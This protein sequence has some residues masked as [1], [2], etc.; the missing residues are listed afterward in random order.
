M[1]RL[2]T[3]LLLFLTI[4]TG[5]AR[6]ASVYLVCAPGEADVE[7]YKQDFTPDVFFDSV[8]I[9]KLATGEYG[10]KINISGLIGTG[11]YTVT[12]QAC[13]IWGCGDISEPFAFNPNVPGASPSML[14]LLVE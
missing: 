3:L 9:Q 13:N 4:S 11:P 6:A 1:T 14:G 7:S 5:A 10:F 8:P 2:L 12:A